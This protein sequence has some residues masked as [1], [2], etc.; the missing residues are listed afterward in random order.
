MPSAGIPIR[1][2]LRM[3]DFEGTS[4]ARAAT[5]ALSQADKAFGVRAF[6]DLGHCPR[7]TGGWVCAGEDENSDPNF[8]FILLGFNRPVQPRFT[9]PFPWNAIFTF[10]RG[11][12]RPRI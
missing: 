7:A 6:C 12:L 11:G 9:D 3:F 1:V 10:D 4:S 8:C 2:T 5:Q